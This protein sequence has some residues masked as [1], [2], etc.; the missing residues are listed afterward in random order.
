M[1]RTVLAP[2]F[3]LVGYHHW[4]QVFVFLFA[5]VWLHQRFD[6]SHSHCSVESKESCDSDS[7][8]GQRTSSR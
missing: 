5:S 6:G 3:I 7:V 2:A 1:L 8:K 4:R